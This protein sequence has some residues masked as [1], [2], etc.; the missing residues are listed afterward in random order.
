VIN[1]VLQNQKKSR[2]YDLIA[3]NGKSV[4]LIEVKNK[5]SVKHIDNLLTTQLKSFKKDFPEYGNLKLY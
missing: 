5:V 1:N 4:I 2:E 3:I